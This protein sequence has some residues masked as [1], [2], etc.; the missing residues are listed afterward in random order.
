MNVDW[1]RLFGLALMDF[2]AGSPW[3]V[4]VEKDL[5]VK[6][7]YLDVVILRREPGEFKGKLPDGLDHLADHNLLTYKSHHEPLDDWSLKEL[8]GIT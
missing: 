4:D 1:H 8:T 2:F 3:R 7:Q 6:Q 5:S